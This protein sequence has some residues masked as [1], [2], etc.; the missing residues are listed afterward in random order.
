[1][2]VCFEAWLENDLGYRNYP[3]NPTYIYYR[4]NYNGSGEQFGH[5]LSSIYAGCSLQ[6]SKD[7]E[8]LCFHESC[9]VSWKEDDLTWRDTSMMKSTRVKEA[10]KIFLNPGESRR[11]SHLQG[12][13]SKYLENFLYRRRN[14]PSCSFPNHGLQ[15]N[16]H[17]QWS[18]VGHGASLEMLVFHLT[19][20]GYS[21]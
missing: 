13:E 17:L 5:G 18:T 8:H 14:V 1:M 15:K 6:F 16:E 12:N 4:L 11:L 7:G 2:R 9:I 10:Y 19:V 20:R 3:R 21:L